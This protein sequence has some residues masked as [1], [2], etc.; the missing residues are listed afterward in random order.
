M[1]RVWGL[2]VAKGWCRLLPLRITSL[3]GSA[4]ELQV[5]RGT[6]RDGDTGCSRGIG[7]DRTSGR[8][9][10]ED[11]PNHDDYSYSHQLNLP[12]KSNTYT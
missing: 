4:I 9:H 10:H 3:T 7:H 12:L 11:P 8:Y 5:K 1:I 2:Q 6:D